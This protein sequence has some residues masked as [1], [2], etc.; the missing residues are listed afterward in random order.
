ME[1]LLLT[2]TEAARALGMGESKVKAYIRTG[3]LSSV[4]LGKSRRVAPGALR[5]FVAR[6]E[7]DA[8]SGRS[9][10]LR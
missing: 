6:L 1:P 3:E 7:R 8:S 10:E 4:K 5:E 2:V 9:A